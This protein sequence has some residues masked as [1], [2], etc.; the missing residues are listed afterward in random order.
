VI[1]RL[2]T[3]RLFLREWRAEDFDDYAHFL[4]DPDVSR[5]LSGE[6]L[7]RTDAWRNMAVVVGHWVLRGYG[8]WAVERKTDGAFVGRVGLWNPDGWPG[9][10]VGWALGREFWGHGYATEAARAA[11]HFAFLTQN[12]ERILSVIDARNRASQ[13]VAERLGEERGERRE[14]TFQGKSFT[15]DLWSIPRETWARRI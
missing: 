4:A 5:F 12:T 1:P 14:I 7:S 13:K 15:V 2:E 11:M 3:E 9:L 8:M 10:E 6:P